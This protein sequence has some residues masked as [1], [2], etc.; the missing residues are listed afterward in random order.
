[1][2]KRRS[3]YDARYNPDGSL[4]VGYTGNSIPWQHLNTVTNQLSYAIVRLRLTL[5]IG[6]EICVYPP[7]QSWA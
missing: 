5:P 1:M 6:V 3:H 7:D 4:F 2:Y